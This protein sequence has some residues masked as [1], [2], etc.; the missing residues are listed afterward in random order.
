MEMAIP[1][2][3][4]WEIMLGEEGPTFVVNSVAFNQ[5]ICHQLIGQGRLL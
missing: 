1:L 3:N 5:Q 2:V 4:G